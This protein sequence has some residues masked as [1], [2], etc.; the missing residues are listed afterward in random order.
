MRRIK[1]KWNGREMVMGGG[2]WREVGG[3]GGGPW[4]R[5]R[6]YGLRGGLRDAVRS[7]S[8]CAIRFDPFML[9]TFRRATV[10]CVTTLQSRDVIPQRF[11][12]KVRCRL[13]IGTDPPPPGILG[14]AGRNGSGADS[15]RVLYVG[16]FL[17]WKGMHLGLRAFAI[18]AARYPEGSLTMVGA[19]PDEARWRRL[20]EK[21]GVDG[22]VTWV[23]WLAQVELPTLYM[24]HDAFLFPS[25]HDSSGNV[26]LEALSHGLP[27]VCLDLGGPAMIAD[28]RSARIVSTEGRDE[29]DVSQALAEA[30]REI[31]DD[32]A[33]HCALS[34]GARKRAAELTWANQVRSV[35]AEFGVS[36]ADRFD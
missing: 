26:V 22:H 9:Q 17:Y 8:N 31:A 10:I 23:P 18:F 35:Y 25:L 24:K 13:G 5:R 28:A 27:V 15:F 19:G 11:H 32:A 7:L 29:A 12:A 2:G 21:L 16:R 4:S 1:K 34:E 36:D 3:G 20:A 14:V 6:G 33:L 30:L